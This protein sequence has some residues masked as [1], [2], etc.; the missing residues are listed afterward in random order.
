VYRCLQLFSTCLGVCRECDNPSG[1]DWA[2]S[3]ECRKKYEEQVL[4]YPLDNIGTVTGAEFNSNVNEF[5]YKACMAALNKN[6]SSWEFWREL[7]KHGMEYSMRLMNIETR[8]SNHK[9]TSDLFDRFLAY[10]FQVLASN[11]ERAGRPLDAADIYEKKLKM[12]DKARVLRERDKQVTI[13]STNVSLDLNQLLQQVKDGGIVAVY[14]C[15]HCGGK[16]KVDKNV[17]ITKLK[18]CEHCGSEIESMDLADF[19]KT[20]LS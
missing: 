16:L 3:A 19:L 20:A 11:I 9:H 6:N 1:F 15:P 14:R 8:S 10:A 5:W 13:K 7:Q 12:Y 17:D 4:S 18:I 2:C